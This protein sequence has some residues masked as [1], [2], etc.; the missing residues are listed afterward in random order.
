[1][2]ADA[3]WLCSF[4][5]YNLSNQEEFF[6]LWVSFFYDETFP[7]CSQQTILHVSSAGSITS[8][9]LTNHCQRNGILVIHLNLSLPES[10]DEGLDCLKIQGFVYPLTFRKTEY[11][12]LSM[13]LTVVASRLCYIRTCYLHAQMQEGLENWRV[14]IKTSHHQ[15]AGSGPTF[16]HFLCFGRL[17]VLPTHL[18]LQR[19]FCSCL[20]CPSVFFTL[21]ALICPHSSQSFALCS[22]PSSLK[23]PRPA[24][25]F[26]IKLLK[27]QLNEENLVV[28]QVQQVQTM[29]LSAFSFF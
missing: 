18:C 16:Q 17:L 11:C 10:C 24:C 7:R 3:K 14:G 5:Y 8:H 21:H 26:T 20:L 29:T 9:L 23:C 15:S 28:P 2:A 1:M 12:I 27:F 4:R 25:S 6:L 13:L 19:S 22:Q